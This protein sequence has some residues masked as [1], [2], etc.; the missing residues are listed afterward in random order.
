MSRVT[1]QSQDFHAFVYE[2]QDYDCGSKLGYF[3]AVMAF[4]KAHAEIGKDA[5][6]M[7]KRF[8]AS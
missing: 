6:A 1:M 4:A 2:G 7:I 5:E 3:E 8:A